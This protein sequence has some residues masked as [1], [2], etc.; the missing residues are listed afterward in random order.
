MGLAG[1]RVGCR[2]LKHHTKNTQSHQQSEKKSLVDFSVEFLPSVFAVIKYLR[3]GHM[4][5]IA[6]SLLLASACPGSKPCIETTRLI[7][8]DTELFISLVICAYR[9]QSLPPLQSPVH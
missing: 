2:Q 7:L 1:A 3:P 8:H 9:L 6:T 5:F 4:L